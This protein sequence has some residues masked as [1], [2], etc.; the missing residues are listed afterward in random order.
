MLSDMSTIA[1]DSEAGSGGLEELR[2]A[3]QAVGI[4]QERLAR[5][6]DCSLST[7]RLVEN[8]WRPSAAMAER[9]LEALAVVRR[10]E[11]ASRPRS[12]RR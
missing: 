12:N 4:S 8:G 9:I 5:R 11:E 1:T 2:A 7:I 6:V 10:E 3:R